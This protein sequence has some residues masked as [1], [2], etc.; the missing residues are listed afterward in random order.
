MTIDE[1]SNPNCPPEL[2]A[3]VLRRGK[4]DYVS[5]NAAYNPNCPPEDKYNWLVK[6]NRL[7]KELLKV[8]GVE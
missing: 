4:D 2:L 1:A 5:Q 7:S 6:I 3:E 8:Y